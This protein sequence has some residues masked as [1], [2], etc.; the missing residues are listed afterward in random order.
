MY[1]EFFVPKL[2]RSHLTTYALTHTVVTV[3]LGLSIFA[4]FTHE[5]PWTMEPI[6]FYFALCN[7]FVFNIFEFG[8]KTFTS[9]EEELAIESYSKVFTRYGAV[10]LVIGMATLALFMLYF[11]QNQPS[12]MQTTLYLALATIGFA[13]AKINTAA[14]GKIYRRFSSGYIILFYLFFII[15]MNVKL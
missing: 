9:G 7:W 5:F 12:L 1:K 15:E 14:W 4:V 6:Y 8:R 3:P 10:C 2:I 13:Y 11:I